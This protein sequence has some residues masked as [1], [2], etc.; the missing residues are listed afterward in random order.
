M[1]ASFPTSLPSF[2]NPTLTENLGNMCGGLGQVGAWTQLYAE[3][4][5]ALAKIGI[6]GSAVTT[7][8]NYKLSGVTGTDKAVSL[9]GT[10]ALTNKTFTS[11]T[12]TDKTSTGTDTGTETLTHKTLTSPVINTPTFSAGAVKAADIETQQAW[13]APSLLNSWVNYGGNQS[14][15]GYMKD[16][17][18]FVHLRGFIKSGTIGTS[19]FVL[20]SGYRP[21]YIVQVATVSQSA[22]GECN[23]LQD[24]SVQPSVGSNTWF[25]LDGII[26]KAV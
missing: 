3:L 24:G 23:I 17:L 8:L 15:A 22:F 11:P 19:A 10:E 18:G 13:Q 16:S 21:E 4:A 6:N 14:I 12:I 7:S 1:P 2:T 5:A 20:P 9:T 25:S 26:F